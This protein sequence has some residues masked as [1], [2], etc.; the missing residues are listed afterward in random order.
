MGVALRA[1]YDAQIEGAFDTV[2]GGLAWIKEQG[3]AP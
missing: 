1:A 2:E 3:F